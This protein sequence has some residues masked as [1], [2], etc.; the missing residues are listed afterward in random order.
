M[1][2][3]YYMWK[4]SCLRNIDEACILRAND[5]QPHRESAVEHFHPGFVRLNVTLLGNHRRKSRRIC[6][7][8]TKSTNCA[9]RE[10]MGKAASPPFPLT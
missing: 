10:P 7:M 2:R 8:A 9:G 4:D 6:T 5:S 1:A 3:K